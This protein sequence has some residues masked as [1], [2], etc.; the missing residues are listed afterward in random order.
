MNNSSTLQQIKAL[1]ANNWVSVW[2]SIGIEV[3]HSGRHGSCPHCGGTDR[4]RTFRNEADRG[5]WICTHCGTGDGL[6]LV[7]LCFECSMS[8]ALRKTSQALGIDGAQ[9]SDADIKRAQQKAAALRVQ[10]EKQEQEAAAK[11]SLL[12]SQMDAES[13]MIDAETNPYLHRKGFFGFPVQALSHDY[14]HQHDG[15]RYVYLSGSLFVPAFD[16]DG[17]IRTGEVI[18]ADGSKMSLAGGS[19]R[20][21]FGYVGTLDKPVDNITLVGVVEGY[22]TALSVRHLLDDSPV[23]V[24]FSKN[25]LLGAAL[26][27]KKWFPNAKIIICG[28]IGAEKEAEQAALSVSGSASIP[29][30]P[31]SDWD[32]YRQAVDRGEV[33]A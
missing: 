13:G 23:F 10:R 19:R 17:Q 24:G 5:T 7:K 8:E 9:V 21:C 28:D 16:I 18:N 29:P 4:F 3:P 6:D 27:A 32:D 1:A 2:G 14:V 33:A 31:Y 25:G 22:A 26:A 11:V 15:K 12:A 30:A 20:G